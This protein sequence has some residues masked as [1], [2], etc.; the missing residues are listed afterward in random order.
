MNLKMIFDLLSHS[1]LSQVSIGGTNGIDESNW[2]RVLSAVNLGLTELHKRFLLREEEVVLQMQPGQV[3]YLLDMK[4]A[5]ANRESF[6]V[7]KYLLDSVADPF[8]GRV[9]KVE[10][11]YD[12]EGTELMLNRGGDALDLLHRSIRTPVFNVLV[13]PPELPLQQLRVVYRGN[14]PLLVKE[15]GYF[16][17]EEVEVSLPDT[18]LDALL[19]FVAARLFNPTG[20]S[21]NTGFHE[22]NNYYQKFEAACAMLDNADYRN[23]E[24]EENYRL[25]RMGWA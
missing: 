19:C 1:E 12:A 17:L 24:K 22:G 9:L 16:Q 3:R 6:G 2:E 15:Q 25:H 14:H 11:V 21:G 8:L 10:R 18:H 13:L 7:T 4:H 5:V 23:V 20:L